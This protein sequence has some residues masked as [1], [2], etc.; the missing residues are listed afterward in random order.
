M[1]KVDMFE[2]I[3]NDGK[4]LEEIDK[5]DIN[6]INTTLSENLPK[7]V[8]N[9]NIKTEVDDYIDGTKNAYEM[10]QAELRKEKEKNIE[11]E[12]I[13]KTDVSNGLSL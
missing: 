7:V 6:G 9:E 1:K 11:T 13:E 2:D 3:D 8:Y 5:I 12:I 10:Q 4:L